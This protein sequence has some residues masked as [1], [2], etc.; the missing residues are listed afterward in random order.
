MCAELSGS[1]SLNWD[2][3]GDWLL[4]NRDVRFCFAGKMYNCWS[5]LCD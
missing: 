4:Y 5:V 2:L 3:N 1:S